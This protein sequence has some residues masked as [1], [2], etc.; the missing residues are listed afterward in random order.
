MKDK[1]F[2]W[3][4]S[5]ISEGINNGNDVTHTLDPWSGINL[6]S[7]QLLDILE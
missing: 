1:H 4:K 3:Q 2:P 7:F 5:N 6:S